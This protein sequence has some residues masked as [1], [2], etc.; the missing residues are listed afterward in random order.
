MHKGEMHWQDIGYVLT[1]QSQ[2]SLGND[3]KFR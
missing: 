3:T 1:M 2:L